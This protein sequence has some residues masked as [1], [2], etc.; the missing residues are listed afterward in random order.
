MDPHAMIPH[1]LALLAYFRGEASAQLVI[2]RDDGV[3]A[4]L[5]V[6]HFFR[7]PAE[8]SPIEVAAL[9]H[10]RG[11]VLDI[12]A[13]TGLHSLALLSQG[14]AVTAIDISP[15]AV[16]IMARRGVPDV[17]CAD[18]FDFQEGPFD[19]LLMLGHSIGI[20]ED[21]QGLSRFLAHARRLTRAGGDLLLDSRDVRQ[22][23]DPRHQA[24]HEANRRAGRYVGEIR[25]Q[26][27]YAGQT[28]PYCGWLH[29]DPETLRKQGE[30]AG[31][32]CETILELASGDYLAGLAPMRAA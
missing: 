32:Q 22:T 6:S 27:E 11:H 5:P 24:Y 4:A 16:E 15:Q 17:H 8:F 21:L 18:I 9:E 13:G 2:R 7:P 14:R 20:V 3:E 31:W 29:V 23:D 28:G 26:L 25:L 12:G 30:L 19:T 10:C 1:G